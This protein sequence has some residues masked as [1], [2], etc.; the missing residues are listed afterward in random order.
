MLPLT[1]ARTIPC[2]TA[3]TFASVYE[4]AREVGFPRLTMHSGEEGPASWVRQTVFD[5]GINR[6]DHGVHAAD[7]DKLLDELAPRGTF[8]TLCPLSNVRLRVHKSVSESPIP[9][10]LAKGIKFSLNSDDPAYFGGASSPVPFL[11][12]AAATCE[13]DCPRPLFVQATSSTTTS[14]CTTRS[15]STRRRGARLRRT[16]STGHGARTSARR[17]C[18][19]TSSASWSSGRARR[20]EQDDLGLRA[21]A[22]PGARCGRGRIDPRLRRRG[23]DRLGRMHCGGQ[24]K[25]RRG[26]ERV[27]ETERERNRCEKGADTT[28]KTDRQATNGAAIMR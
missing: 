4:T 19:R 18:R 13:T 25:M 20:S 6:V 14:L 23:M 1:C 9:K 26:R 27:R 28:K 5:L 3:S 15:S 24:D 11:R 17:P 22:G 10:L 21:R 7:D 2:T 12:P 16:A 8:F